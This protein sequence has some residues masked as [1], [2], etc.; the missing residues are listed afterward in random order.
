MENN[1]ITTID[2]ETG[3]VIENDW[4]TSLV[5]DCKAIITE[6]VFISRWSLVEGYHQLGERIVTDKNYREHAKGNK[7]SVQGLARNL[8]TSERTLYYAMQFYEKYP[9]LD[10]VPEGKNISW[11]KIITKY[12]PKPKT[13]TPTL[14]DGK[15]NIIYA[16]PPW[17]YSDK[18]IEGYGAAD[19]HYPQMTIE[20]LCQLP[21][22]DLAGDN[23]VLFVWVTSPLL[24]DVFTIIKAWGFQYKT[25]FVWD[26]V[27]HNF[28]HYNSVRHELLLVCTRGSCTPDNLKLYDSVQTIERTDK[29]SQK[30]EQFRAIIDTLYPDGKRIELFGRNMVP[31]WEVWGNELESN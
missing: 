11:N 9:D 19:H 8:N 31:G 12:L 25:S 7:S 15:Y 3:E 23:S 17:K 26:K 18:L 10:M 6:A 20:E 29:H 16:D 27:K 5:D 30:P 2:Y 14:P 13:E 24:E 28:G 1:N 22:Q 21:V 4:Y